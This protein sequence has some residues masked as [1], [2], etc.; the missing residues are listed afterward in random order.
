VVDLDAA[1]EL[2]ATH[3]RLLD[4]RRL[5][6]VI[7]DALPDGPRTALSAYRNPD[8]G[9]G[10]GLEAELRDTRS[11][12]GAA[13]HAFEVFE[14][15]IP[16]TTARA[17]ELCD[18][19]EPVSLSDGGLPFALPV[20]SAG[21]CAPFSV[22]ADPAVSSLQITAV[23]TAIAHRVAANDPAVAGHPRLT[24]AG[25]FCLRAIE[26]DGRRPACARARLRSA[27]GARAIRTRGNIC[28]VGASGRAA[29]GRRLAG[30]IR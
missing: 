9:Y 6:I 12:P 5:D 29:A 25:Q 23:V 22:Q 27:P 20:T 21:G 4:R 8:G 17:V 13:L 18:W 26:A 19:L 10:W 11:Q 3:A 30:R 1:H 16:A 28:R 15:S 7:H 14:D 24:R 2:M